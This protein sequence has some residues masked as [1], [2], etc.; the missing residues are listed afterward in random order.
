[1]IS[2]KSWETGGGRLPRCRC[3][4][5]TCFAA[6]MKTMIYKPRIVLKLKGTSLS[7]RRVSW[8]CVTTSWIDMDR[9]ASERILL[10]VGRALALSLRLHSLRSLVLRLPRSSTPPRLRPSSI[11]DRIAAIGE[12]TE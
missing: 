4:R 3:R 10:E 9:P 1:M 7:T 12:V 8:D 11:G 2:R 6:I 5:C